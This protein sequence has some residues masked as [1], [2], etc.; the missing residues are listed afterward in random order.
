MIAP[1]AK[2]LGL[3]KAGPS[4]ASGMFEPM[5]GIDAY[6]WKMNDCRLPYGLRFNKDTTSP[7]DQTSVIIDV[8]YDGICIKDPHSRYPMNF[9]TNFP[10]EGKVWFG[11][12]Q[13]PAYEKYIAPGWHK[14]EIKVA[15]RKLMQY[16]RGRDFSPEAGGVTQAFMFQVTGDGSNTFSG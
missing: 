3:F 2:I 6:L 13:P 10:G 1:I 14:V 7:V 8:V 9:V 16:L 15:P 4:G 11:Y 12:F 5:M